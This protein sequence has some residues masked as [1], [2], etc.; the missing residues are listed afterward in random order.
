MA[1]REVI[2]K[3]DNRDFLGKESKGS[4]FVSELWSNE[5]IS[6]YVRQAK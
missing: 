3:F 5:N 6:R 1:F 4:M 2:F